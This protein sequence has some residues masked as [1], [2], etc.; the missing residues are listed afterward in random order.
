MKQILREDVEAATQTDFWQALS[1]KQQL[2]IQKSIEALDKKE[3]IAH[4]VVM[5]EFRKKL[6]V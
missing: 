5:E 6:N 2:Q 1:P 4:S 3:G